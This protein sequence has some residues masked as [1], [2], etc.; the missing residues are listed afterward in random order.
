MDLAGHDRPVVEC[1]IR[2]ADRQCPTAGGN[3]EGDR[4]PLAIPENEVQLELRCSGTDHPESY[5]RFESSVRAT[6]AGH[7]GGEHEAV[8]RHWSAKPRLWMRWGTDLEF[9]IGGDHHD[10]ARTNIVEERPGRSCDDRCVAT[11]EMGAE[12]F[13]PTGNGSSDRLDSIVW[14]SQLESNDGTGTVD[15]WMIG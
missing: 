8:A 6:S 1:R 5:G 4:G 7:P 15:S 2:R 10:R 11:G 14:V 3:A 12:P 9:G 13:E